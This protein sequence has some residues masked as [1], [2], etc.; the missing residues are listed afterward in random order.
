MDNYIQIDEQGYL[1]LDQKRVES[2][3]L[4]QQLLQN[5]KTPSLQAFT[6][7][8]N[9][10]HYIVEAFDAPIVVQDTSPQDNTTWRAV[11]NYSYTTQFR[12]DQLFLDEWDR[13]LG[14]DLEGRPFV[15]SRT[16]HSNFFEQIDE[17][18]DEGI[19][20]K[21]TRYP[22]EPWLKAQVSTSSSDF[23]NS[24][25]LEND[26]PG[27]ELNKPSPVL[28]QALPQ[29][30][31]PR[32]RILV[33]GCGSG[34]DAAFLAEQGHIVTAVDYSEQAIKRAQSKYGHIKNLTFEQ[35]DI[36]QLPQSYL[37]A[38]DMIFEHTLFCAVPIERRQELVKIWRRCLCEG[39]LL[40]AVLFVMEQKPHP[41]FG[42]SE[43][44]YRQRLKDD[45]R[46]LYWTR[47]RESEGW[48]NGVELL[49]HAQIKEKF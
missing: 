24:K 12:L 31:I 40:L 27:W 13:I 46:L 16:A 6:T 35:I 1:Y 22:L 2:E 4:G 33:P 19:T 10:I 14:Y 7:T 38:F 48:R 49:I 43:W 26:T 29:L 37:H 17:F 44:E 21:K 9:N 18:D 34:N 15:M 5:L 39:G 11:G 28:T 25:Y 20:Y 23:W 32:S 30:K 3:V 8:A 41:P 42:G 47:W 45:F 36:F